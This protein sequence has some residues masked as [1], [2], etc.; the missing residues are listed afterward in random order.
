MEAYTCRLGSGAGAVP[1]KIAL[2]FPF[3]LSDLEFVAAFGKSARTT[4]PEPS[5]E[6]ALPHSDQPR[7]VVQEHHARAMHWDFRL[8]RDGVL[9]SWAVPKGVPTDPA[10]NRLAVHVDDHALDHATYTAGEYG[11]GAMAEK[12]NLMS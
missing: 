5:P 6:V 9:V 4:T 2:Q 8:E 1:L 10:V 7:F 12:L 3:P 11:V